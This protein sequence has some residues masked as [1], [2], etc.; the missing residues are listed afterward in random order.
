MLVESESE[1]YP[2]RQT[3]LVSEENWEDLP[4]PQTYVASGA[5]VLVGTVQIVGDA[6]EELDEL[7]RSEH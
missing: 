1:S 2:R 4:D 6:V 7:Y 5:C 3:L